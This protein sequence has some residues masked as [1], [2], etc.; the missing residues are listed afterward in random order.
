LS[1]QRDGLDERSELGASVDMKIGPPIVVA[2]AEGLKVVAISEGLGDGTALGSVDD[3]KTG[4]FDPVPSIGSALGK[5]E[6]TRVSIEEGR[7]DAI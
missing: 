4:L 7:P 2:I 6:G 5:N 1:W 3:M